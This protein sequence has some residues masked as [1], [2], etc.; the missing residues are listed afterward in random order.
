MFNIYL[1]MFHC[2]SKIISEEG[3]QSLYRGLSPALMRQASYGTIKFGLYYTIKEAM[4]GGSESPLKNVVCAVIAGSLSSSIANPT[5]VLK[6]RNRGGSNPGQQ[7]QSC[8]TL[9]IDPPVYSFVTS[10]L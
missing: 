4:P 10:S 1:G 3:A 6:V 7:R 2:W 5:D 9:L 8:I